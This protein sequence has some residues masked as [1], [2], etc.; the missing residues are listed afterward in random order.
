MKYKTIGNKLFV[1][2]EKGEEVV[3]KLEQILEEEGVHAGS[4]QG[5]GAVSKATLGHYSLESKDYSE[6]E[7]DQPLEIVSLQGT[8]SGEGVHPHVCLGT[9][10]MKTYGGHLVE[11][12]VAATCEIIVKPE[13]GG[14]DRYYD[15]EIGLDLLEL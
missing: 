10:D 1:R 5:I 14:L 15:E 13:P 11:A 3:S 7:L 6:K 2:L 4:F 12:V 8:V 9:K